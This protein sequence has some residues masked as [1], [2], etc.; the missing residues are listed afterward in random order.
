MAVDYNS[1]GGDSSV[2]LTSDTFETADEVTPTGGDG[3]E[4]YEFTGDMADDSWD[5]SRAEPEGETSFWNPPDALDDP[6]QDPK[7]TGAEVLG[8]NDNGWSEDD[9][10]DAADNVDV[11][12]PDN[13]D[14]SEWEAPDVDLNPFDDLPWWSKYAAAGGVVIVLLVLL[15]PYAELGAKAA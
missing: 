2:S 5:S 7:D 11:T 15:A 14:V 10:R 4:D 9:V 3:S 12:N 13:Y 6:V 8:E 1:D